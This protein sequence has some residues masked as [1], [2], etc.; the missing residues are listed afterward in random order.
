MK[1]GI[2]VLAGIFDK[3]YVCEE[4]SIASGMYRQ[5]KVGLKG[6]IKLGDWLTAELYSQYPSKLVVHIDSNDV[7]VIFDGYIS[8]FVGSEKSR[9]PYYQSA[10]GIADL[11]KSLG[12]GFVVDLRGSFTILIADNRKRKAILV[13]DRLG[14]RPLFYRELASG[15]LLV[16]PS[17]RAASIFSPQLNE[18]NHEAIG[19]FLTRGCYC[20]D[21]TLY[22]NVFRFPQG[23]KL[24]IQK[25][26]YKISRYWSISFSEKSSGAKL[27]DLVEEYDSLLMQA[28]KRCLISVQNPVIFLSGGRDSRLVLGCLL[29]AGI[30]DIPAVS[31]ENDDADGDDAKVAYK[32]A[33]HCNLPFN[34]YKIMLT[35]F[36]L[37]ARYAVRRVEGRAYVLDAPSLTN[38]WD[39]LGRY[40]NSFFNGDEWR[41]GWRG[42][43]N[44]IDQALD[45]IGLFC[46]DDASRINDWFS[47]SI[48]ASIIRAMRQTRLQ[49]AAETNEKDLNNIKDKL[50]YQERTGNGHNCFTAARLDMLEQ[51]RPM[52]DEDVVDFVST[53]PVERRSDKLLTDNLLET[54]Y[55]KINT[56]P[57]SIKDS[58]PLGHTSYEFFC[59]EN[60]S[61]N[62]ILEN[63]ESIHPGLLEVLDE[64]QFKKTLSALLKN[65]SLPEMRKKW[66]DKIPGAW[67]FSHQRNL[68]HPLTGILRL[69]ELNLFLND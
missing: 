37:T 35:D 38:L 8:D 2:S 39:K 68:V 58:L 55:S 3:N 44:S 16:G 12:E 9:V 49:I 42:S 22:K 29:S 64:K 31:W 28:T 26:R 48:S 21:H 62:Y 61:N 10:T 5:E 32:L 54:K 69:L 53:L 36:H 7:S 52:L 11:Y 66:V 23:G 15:S 63:F 51:A 18:L 65:E 20:S 50:F 6:R 59:S 24:V 30:K 25:S 60:S 41:V 34:L 13:N 47:P 17:L 40:H 45:H 14:S 67:R 33:N 19:E 56:L 43:A 4:D 27:K 1:P 57:Y 46:L